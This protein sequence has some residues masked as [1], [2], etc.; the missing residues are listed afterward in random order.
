M[1]PF[2]R[3]QKTP[4]KAEGAKMHIHTVALICQSIYSAGISTVPMLWGLPRVHWAVSL[5]R[6]WWVPSILF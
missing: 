6:S 2:Y 3:Q 5:T 1:S 4:C